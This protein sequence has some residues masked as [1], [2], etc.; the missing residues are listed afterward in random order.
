[1]VRLA[2]GRLDLRSAGESVSEY[3]LFRDDSGP[4]VGRQLPHRC[5]AA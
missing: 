1:M 3:G 5:I 2:A 4:G